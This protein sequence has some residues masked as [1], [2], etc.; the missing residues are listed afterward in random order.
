MFC[1]LLVHQEESKDHHLNC[2]CW[3]DSTEHNNHSMVCQHVLFALLTIV[4][5]CHEQLQWSAEMVVA[6]TSYHHP[7]NWERQLSQAIEKAA[8][9]NVSLSVISLIQPL[10]CQIDFRIQNT[11]IQY[12]CELPL[13]SQIA[14]HLFCPL[15]CGQPSLLTLNSRI[16]SSNN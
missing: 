13:R 4:P 8:G 3:F 9:A 12:I 2:R 6:M 1:N 14:T 5:S 7:P 16:P 10:L 15:A 11:D